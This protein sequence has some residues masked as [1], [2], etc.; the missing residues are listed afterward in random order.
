MAINQCFFIQTPDRS[1]QSRLP[2]PIKPKMTVDNEDGNEAVESEADEENMETNDDE[3]MTAE[4]LRSTYHSS[5]MA[6][7]FERLVRPESVAQNG[8]LHS[9][10]Y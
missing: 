6:L 4:R 2:P 8:I 1:Q 9:F 10:L 7:A 5:D 3:K